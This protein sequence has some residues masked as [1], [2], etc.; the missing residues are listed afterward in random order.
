MDNYHFLAVQNFSLPTLAFDLLR[1]FHDCAAVA[2]RTVL[3]VTGI[4]L[5]VKVEKV[6]ANIFCMVVMVSF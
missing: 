6:T 3:Q 1:L 2:K 5:G 4:P